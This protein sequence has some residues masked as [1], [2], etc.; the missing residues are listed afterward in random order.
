MTSCSPSDPKHPDDHT[1]T[2]VTFP[3]PAGVDSAD[4]WGAAAASY[5]GRPRRRGQLRRLGLAAR[6]LSLLP[7]LVPTVAS[8]VDLVVH[9][10][11]DA[12]G[13]RRVSEI[14][15]VPGRVEDYSGRGTGCWDHVAVGQ[16]ERRMIGTRTREG[17]PGGGDVSEGGAGRR[18][19][20]GFREGSRPAGVGDR[21]AQ[22]HGRDCAHRHGHPGGELWI[23]TGWFAAVDRVRHAA[24]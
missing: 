12:D 17:R 1:R 3:E 22:L 23:T 2:D 15:G 6:G 5:G 10:Q 11:Q 4:C 7:I 9:V 19:D 13:R 8:S 24:S 14:A 20:L 16:W 18:D 21:D